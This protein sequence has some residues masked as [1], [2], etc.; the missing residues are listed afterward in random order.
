MMKQQHLYQAAEE[1]PDGVR[2][3][4]L[5]WILSVADTKHRI[6]M[7][8]SHWV[9]GTPALEAAVGS[10]ALTQDE[11]GH[12]RSLYALLRRYPDAPEAVGA[13]NDLE[14][15]D[16]YYAPAALNPTWESWLQV[17]A[18]NLTL[19]AALQI[20][21]AQATDSA[22]QPLAGRISKILQEERFHR[23]FGQSWL[24]RLAQ[25][26]DQTK[27]QL[28]RQIAWAWRITDA[29]IG[30]ED[31]PVMKT[32]ADVGVLRGG[33]AAIRQQWREEVEPMLINSGITPPEPI[34][35]WSGWDAQFRQNNHA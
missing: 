28:Q 1:M 30:P 25:H 34:T 7:Q 12:A 26:S 11:L 19:D 35:D 10:A 3:A 22:Y 2:I 9:T 6:G 29:W 23:V 16:V 20:A 32:L 21:I 18:V 17:V 4:L 24:A 15:R 14:A 5:Q 31:D 8:N 33:T 13:E 27:A